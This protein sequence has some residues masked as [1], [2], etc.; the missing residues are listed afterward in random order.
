M[1]LL[2]KLHYFLAFYLFLTHDA[3]GLSCTFPVP[4]LEPTISQG[5]LLVRGDIQKQGMLLGVFIVNE[6][7]LFVVPLPRTELRNIHI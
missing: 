1:L 2:W 6:A 3:L 5:N 7:P 4:I